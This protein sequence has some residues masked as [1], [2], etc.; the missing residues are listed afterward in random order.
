MT[1]FE[2]QS[3]KFLLKFEI[4]HL[5]IRH[6]HIFW[7]AFYFFAKISLAQTTPFEVAAEGLTL[8]PPSFEMTLKPGEETAHTI[9]ITNPTK[10]PD[11]ALSSAGNFTPS[12]GDGGEPKYEIGTTAPRAAR[13]SRSP[14]GSPFLYPKVALPE[15]VVEFRFRIKVPDDAEPG[16]HYGVASS[17]PNLPKTKTKRRRSPSPPWSGSLLLVRIPGD[18]REEMRVEEFSAPWFFWT[19]PVAFTLFLRNTG[20]VHTAPFGRYRHRRLARTHR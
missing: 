5:K 6:H 12:S 3:F 7:Q 17:A 19:P 9:Q 13:A 15:Q 14:T 1:N 16:G 4:Y 10:N 18:I 11:R 2:I 8:S 20:T